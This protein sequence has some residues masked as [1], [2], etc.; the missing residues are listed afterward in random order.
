MESI[1]KKA[2]QLRDCAQ[3]END[4]AI[5]RE[6]KKHIM[7]MLIKSHINYMSM[8]CAFAVYMSVNQKRVK[9]AKYESE[10]VWG[11]HYI[12][13][14]IEILALQ[15]FGRCSSPQP[16]VVSLSLFCFSY[17]ELKNCSGE[18]YH[19]TC[20][21]LM[22]ANPSGKSNK[23]HFERSMKMALFCLPFTET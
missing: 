3:N 22:G 5:W 15:I 1:S 19:R 4:Y 13:A 11:V 23:I 6:K 16:H 10:C 2:W 12:L 7:D 9:T 21:C 8:R 14:L 20:L 17:M 18:F